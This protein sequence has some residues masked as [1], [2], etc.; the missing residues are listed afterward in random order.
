MSPPLTPNPMATIIT[1]G[2]DYQ[3]L[4][5]DLR[6]LIRHEIA[7]AAPAAIPDGAS[8]TD[9]PLTVQG[10]AE[11]LNVCVATV[12]EWKRRGLLAYTKI[13]GRTYLK[14]SDVLAAG[15]TQQRTAKPARPKKP[16][17]G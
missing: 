2:V 10:A 13:G 15:T 5:D 12:H 16:P 3:Q 17:S 14:R 6:A 4:L 7:Q 9:E 8:V 1:H 11:L